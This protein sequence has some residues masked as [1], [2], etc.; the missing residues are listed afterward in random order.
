MPPLIP[1]ATRR[2]V[3]QCGDVLAS[4]PTAR[5]DIYTITVL[6]AVHQVM[7]GGYDHAVDM[8][9]R[10]AQLHVVDGW[11]TCNHIHFVRVARHRQSPE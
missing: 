7:A 2:R 1:L 4:R 9:R 8:V 10:L 6:P 3:P 5:S 11:Y